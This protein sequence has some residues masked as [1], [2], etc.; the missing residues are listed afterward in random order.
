MIR[1]TTRSLGAGFNT[2]VIK[3][4][5]TILGGNILTTWSEGM[6]A[7]R[8]PFL[9]SSKIAEVLSLFV[10]SGAAG[11]FSKKFLSK[12]VNPSDVL[13][14]GILAGIT[15]GAKYLLPGT[16]ATCG[17]GDDEGFMGLGEDMDG[18]GAFYHPGMQVITPNGMFVNHLNGMGSYAHKG[19][20]LITLNGGYGMGD[21]AVVPQTRAPLLINTALDGMGAMQAVGEEIGMQM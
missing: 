16:F 1:T 4:A 20:P 17:L 5:S 13:I 14:G 19:Q 9:R 10:L 7:S 11:V 6:I 2:K 15:R 18:L 3:Q 8:L 21:S 12:F